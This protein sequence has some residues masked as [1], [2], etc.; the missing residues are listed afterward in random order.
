MRA[1]KDV[2]VFPHQIIPDGG[3]ISGDGQYDYMQNYLRIQFVE[4]QQDMSGYRVSVN[5]SKE[6]INKTIYL[7]FEL[8]YFRYMFDMDYSAQDLGAFNTPLYEAA[9]RSGGTISSIAD[10]I[11]Q[12]VTTGDG[13]SEFANEAIRFGI[14]TAVETLMTSDVRT[15]KGAKFSAGLAY[16]SNPRMMFNGKGTKFRAIS[17]N[18]DLMPRNVEEARDVYDIESAFYQYTLP[19]KFNVDEEGNQDQGLKKYFYAYTYPNKL[20]IQPFV[21]GKEYNKH[22]FFPLVVVALTIAH[23]GGGANMPHFYED[24]EGRKYPVKTSIQCTLQETKI[25]TRE[26]VEYLTGLSNTPTFI[27]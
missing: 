22:R 23:S 1:N 26:D 15:I 13:A 14:G 8:E 17:M 12:G 9:Q 3:Q 2:I 11:K 27:T 19:K 18:W 5:P 7:P 21:G 20:L 10:A 24:E 25:A 6:R 4:H 16:N